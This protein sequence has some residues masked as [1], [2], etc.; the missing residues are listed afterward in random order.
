MP[1]D[2]TRLILIPSPSETRLLMTEGPDDLLLAK[3]AP[4]TSVRHRWA[5]PMLLE[6]LSLWQGRPV[7]VVISAA[8]QDYL[9][10]LG[11][12][13]G[14]GLG[15]STAHYVVDV[16]EPERIRGRRLRGLGDFREARR[17]LRLVWSR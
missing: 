6:A 5:G 14:L 3:L 11:L 10:P 9:Y 16:T 12:A 4:V 8:A 1:P 7:R 2:E 17:Q 13:D 15:T